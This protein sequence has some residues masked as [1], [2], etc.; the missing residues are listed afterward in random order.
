ML[1]GLLKIMISFLFIL[2]VK[3]Q[4]GTQTAWDGMYKSFFLIF[5]KIFCT[6]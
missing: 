6:I 1:R 2:I 3:G 5:L 4:E